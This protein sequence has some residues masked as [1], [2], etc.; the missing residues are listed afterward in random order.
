MLNEAGITRSPSI[1]SLSASSD[2]SNTSTP[3]SKDDSIGS[4]S[5]YLR[6]NLYPST[7][8]DIGTDLHINVQL[9]SEDNPI[10]KYP[11][12][13]DKILK[14]AK[15]DSLV[16]NEENL[17]NQNA[18]YIRASLVCY[19]KS[20][21]ESIV[22]IK[23]PYV[24]SISDE[25]KQAIIN[26]EKEKIKTV[27]EDR[28][29]QLSMARLAMSEFTFIRSQNNDIIELIKELKAYKTI[30]SSVAEDL[31]QS[32][33]NE[34]LERCY[35]IYKPDD[36]FHSQNLVEKLNICIKEIHKKLKT[37]QADNQ[38]KINKSN[39]SSIDKE[40]KKVQKISEDDEFLDKVVRQERGHSED[41][42]YDELAQESSRESILS[43][44]PEGS[45][46]FYLTV[47]STRDSCDRCS[48]KMTE[49]VDLLSNYIKPHCA[50]QGIENI[51]LKVLYFANQRM[52][53]RCS[54]REYESNVDNLSDEENT[55]INFAP[56][57]VMQIYSDKL[58]SPVTKTPDSLSP[59]ESW[60]SG[61]DSLSDSQS[62]NNSPEDENTLSRVSLL[63]AFDLVD[64]KKIF[65]PTIEE[66]FF[67]PERAEELEV[68]TRASQEG[69]KTPE[70]IDE[71]KPKSI[72]Q[73]ASPPRLFNNTSLV[74][75]PIA[76]K[77]NSK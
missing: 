74:L 66:R 40:L 32:K 21:P 75:T 24:D 44:I 52:H 22:E 67:T 42:L 51:D 3:S 9:I 5:D 64:D 68:S 57:N 30:L 56:F 43:K 7:Y 39:L 71:E 23:I 35:K 41:Y 17:Y 27:L 70:N 48:Y 54:S 46:R 20:S 8:P 19:S 38:F 58:C 55:V 10:S 50:T 18:N 45:N 11:E 26:L 47:F 61:F 25:R 28:N 72:M 36:A 14:I 49:I 16:V 31:H 1:S 6:Y 13:N 62:R 69:L 34:V 4:L 77:G 12:V 37:N 63:K 33:I 15:R 29:L 60:S 2:Y 76:T 59:V 73:K 65:T 53:R